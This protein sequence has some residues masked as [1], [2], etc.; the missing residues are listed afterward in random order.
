M[1]D[2]HSHFLPGID[3][4]PKLPEDTL[5]MGYIAVHEGIV[6]IAATHH[7]SDD[8]SISVYGEQWLA[9]LQRVQPLLIENSLS[10]QVYS[11]AEVQISPFLHLLE[12]IEALCINASRY[13]L[14]EL[15]MADIPLYTE[16]VIYNL[17]I[18][19]IIPIIAHPER[20][21]R[22]LDNPNLLHPLISLGALGQI[23]SGSITGLFGKKVKRCA[24]ILLEHKMGHLLAS[25]AHSPHNR[26][27]LLLSAKAT[28]DKWLGSGL[29]D[30]MSSTLPKDILDNVLLEMEEPE[31]YKRRFFLP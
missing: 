16:E 15:P 30:V 20:N 26:A 11:G 18:K 27:P 14:V 13:L 28:I 29:G 6:G 8:Q 10:I 17:R 2:L 3:D 7:F 25:D 4:G 21:W 19:G 23:T 1:Y 9:S 31:R 24:R 22:I 12:G 5:A